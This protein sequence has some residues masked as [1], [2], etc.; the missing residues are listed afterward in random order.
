MYKKQ[1]D[2]G[3]FYLELSDF[4]T[5]FSKLTVNH[6]RRTEG[7]HDTWFDVENDQDGEMKKFRFEIAQNLTDNGLIYVTL[8]T[9]MP[10]IVPKICY[11]ND[12][13]ME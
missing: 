12:F 6:L 9:Y 13:P 2:T 7:Y 3:K 11:D 1:G 8:E 4:K 5:C 10:G